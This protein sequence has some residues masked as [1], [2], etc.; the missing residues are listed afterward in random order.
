MLTDQFAFLHDLFDGA[1]Q[2]P[3]VISHPSLFGMKHANP[4]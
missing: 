3:L 1:N 4:V 2:T